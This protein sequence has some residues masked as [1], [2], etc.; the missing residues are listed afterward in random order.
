MP[1]PPSEDLARLEAAVLASVEAERGP[2]ARVRALGR[3]SRLALLVG[4]VA[5]EGLV[6]WLFLRRA[7]LGVYPS[8]RLAATVGGYGGLLIAAGWLALRPLYLPDRPAAR[9]VVV[10][11]GLLLPVVLALLPEVPTVS[12]PAGG[13]ARWATFCFLD[14]A[15]VAAAVLVAGRLLDRGG[16]GASL[17]ALAA[18]MAGTLMLHIHCPINQ[19]VHL[20]VGHATVP[21]VAVA[22]G[23]LLARRG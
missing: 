3:P 20:L 9:R 1:L 19:P 7:D 21:L 2:V 23:L 8:A 18:G 13:P 6:F 17:A 10:A 11:V 14:G 4:V 15:L 12:P 16:P 5:L 22:A